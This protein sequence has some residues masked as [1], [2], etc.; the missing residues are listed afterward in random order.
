M[1]QMTVEWVACVLRAVLDSNCIGLS[2]VRFI[3]PL[4]CLRLPRS[5]ARNA[6]HVASLRLQPS[7]VSVTWLSFWLSF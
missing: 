7:E 5:R 4:C 6:L 2:F 1:Q 3:L